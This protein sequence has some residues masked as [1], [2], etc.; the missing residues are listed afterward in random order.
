MKRTFVCFLLLVLSFS[1]ACAQT[2]LSDPIY[3]R[4]TLPFFCISEIPR[5]MDLIEEALNRMTRAKIGAEVRLVPLLALSDGAPDARR[6][7]ELYMLERE[8][9]SFDLFCDALPDFESLAIPLDDLLRDYGKDI[10][11]VLDAERLDA[12]RQDGVLFS[13]PSVSDYVISQGIAMRKD[14]VET[15]DL[16]LSGIHSIEDLDA[17]FATVHACEPEIGV[18]CGSNTTEAVLRYT[19]DAMLLPETVFCLSDTEEHTLTNYYA[20]GVFAELVSRTRSWHDAGYIAHG[21]SLQNTDAASLVRA[22]ELFSF[23]TSCEPGTEQELS[24]SCGM[25]MTVIPLQDGVVS[26]QSSTMRQWGITRNC[27]NPGKAMQFLNLLYTDS[28][29]VNL[30]LY[31]IEGIHYV[32]REDGTIGYPEGVTSLDVGFANNMPWILPNQ[33]IARVWEG[34]PLDLWEQLKTF[35][36]TAEVTELVGF[37]FDDAEVAAEN[38]E[39]RAIVDECSFGLTTGRLDPEIYLPLMLSEMEDA[40][41]EVVLAEAQE[42]YD[43]WRIAKEEGT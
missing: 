27:A 2:Y 6:E 5:D 20:T 4:L 29:V 3:A 10:L 36:E 23:I 33:Y 16:D 26:A 34:Q 31:G 35:N 37:V 12:Y 17:L 41:L 39:L 13:L 11:D 19:A 25:E 7:A 40:G 28:E 15:Y 24:R 21:A 18:V 42:Q 8:G 32:E 38:A 22:G 9:V 43:R 14:I 1:P 30:L